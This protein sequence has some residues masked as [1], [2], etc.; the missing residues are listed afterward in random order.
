MI[1]NGHPLSR[2]KRPAQLI[3]TSKDNKEN[4]KSFYG[5]PT[6]CSDLA[7]LGYTLNGFYLVKNPVVNENFPQITTTQTVYCAFKQEGTYNQFMVQQPV[8]SSPLPLN[9]LP[10]SFSLP[11]SKPDEDISFFVLG[12]R[13]K[14]NPFY[15]TLTF[16]NADARLNIGDP[17]NLNTGY[18]RTPKNGIYH[19]SFEITSF[20]LR[21]NETRINFYMN[22]ILVTN[23]F[24]LFSEVPGSSKI[25]HQVTLKLKVGDTIC[26][27]ATNK[28][29]R[30]YVSTIVEIFQESV[31]GYLLKT[32]HI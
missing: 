26:L 1:K 5:P 23:T 10:S 24:S 8:I 15:G 27:K 19:F 16:Q 18:F 4:R 13:N 22:D 28:E 12:T 32:I 3:P 21:G 29:N 30:K 9:P 14:N 20:D 17:F 11:T 6:S 25:I 31:T 7:Q 2:R